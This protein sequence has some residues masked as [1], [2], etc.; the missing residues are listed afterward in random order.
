MGNDEHP[1]SSGAAVACFVI[2]SVNTYL[3]TY[4]FALI[5]YHCHN[6]ASAR[7]FQTTVYPDR[8]AATAYPNCRPGSVHPAATNATLLLNANVARS[9]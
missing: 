8:V 7:V 6:A 5:F 1:T 2:L 9:T 4:L 3:L